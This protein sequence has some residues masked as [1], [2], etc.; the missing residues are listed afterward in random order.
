M[1]ALLVALLLVAFNLTAQTRQEGVEVQKSRLLL[2]PASTVENS[3]GGS[4]QP[5]QSPRC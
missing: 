2:L 4:G 1:R 3:A 5:P